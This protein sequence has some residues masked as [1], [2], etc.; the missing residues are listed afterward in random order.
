MCDELSALTSRVEEY[1]SALMEANLEL[2][3]ITTIPKDKVAAAITGK[4]LADGNVVFGEPIADATGPTTDEQLS[5]PNDSA[6]KRKRDIQSFLAEVA[7]FKGLTPTERSSIARALTV[8]EFGAGEA[9]VRQGDAGETMYII[10]LGSA[11]VQI[12]G[13]GRVGT[14]D[15]GSVFGELALITNQPRKATIITITQTTVL[16]LE[17][18]V[19]ERLVGQMGEHLDQLRRRFHAASYSYGRRDYHKLFGHF[20][21]SNTGF[22]DMEQFRACVRK[23]GRMST[24]M[25]SEKE[26]RTLFCV[27]DVDQDGRINEEDFIAFLG[28]TNPA[29]HAKQVGKH[30]QNLKELRAQIEQCSADAKRVMMEGGDNAGE[31][32]Q[33]LLKQVSNPHLI[34]IILT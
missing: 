6:R 15:P 11:A 16:A 20:D 1:R 23:D 31:R 9:I 10:E 17:R 26:L 32:A 30:K 8:E 29:E 4:K 34:L 14:L 18:P 28:V 22:L 2:D 7:L 3:K 27:V 21:R 33:A 24:K 13:V 12:E 25:I 5:T 19:F